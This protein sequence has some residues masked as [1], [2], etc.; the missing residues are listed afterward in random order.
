MFDRK[1]KDGGVS[2]DHYQLEQGK[3]NKLDMVELMVRWAETHC[4]KYRRACL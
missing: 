3:H 2:S 1:L 4:Q